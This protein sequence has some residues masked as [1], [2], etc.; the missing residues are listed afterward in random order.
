MNDFP[1][2]M[3]SNGDSLALNQSHRTTACYQ[4]LLEFCPHFSLFGPWL[5]AALANLEAPVISIRK[6][7]RVEASICDKS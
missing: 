6:S 2:I 7:K 5:P 3:K 1:N 4:M